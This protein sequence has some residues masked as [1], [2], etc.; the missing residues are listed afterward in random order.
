MVL[1]QDLLARPVGG[2]DPV[3]VDRYGVVGDAGV[4]QCLPLGLGPAWCESQ[5]IAD[6]QRVADV[7]AA[8]CCRLPSQELTGSRVER[9]LQAGE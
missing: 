7:E 1:V 3:L 6:D 9:A 2:R 5:R 8:P 4:P